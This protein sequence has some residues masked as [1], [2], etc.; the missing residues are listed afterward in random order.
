M[1]LRL[2]LFIADEGGTL[3]E[4]EMFKDESVTLTQTL[5]NIKDISKVFTDFSKTFSVPA[6]KNNNK[7][8][9]HFYRYEIDGFTSRQKKEAQLYL[10]HQLFK[11]GKVK[12]ETVKLIGNK[13]H[14]Y[15]L[16]FFGEAINMKDFFGEDLIGSLSYLSNFSFEYN[17]ANVI[18]A[19]LIFLIIPLMER[20][21]S[22]DQLQVLQL[23]DLSEYLVS[24]YKLLSRLLPQFH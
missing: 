21:L 22:H 19:L 17:A 9:Q 23:K 20:N 4:V 1:P 18:D 15:N 7:L 6:S 10:N 13:P 16:T 3:T 8:F 12:L 11:K 5:Q 2:N 24:Q 14:T